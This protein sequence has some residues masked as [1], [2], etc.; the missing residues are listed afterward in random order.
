MKTGLNGFIWLLFYNS[1]KT[2]LVDNYPKAYGYGFENFLVISFFEEG[3]KKVQIL[4]NSL[5]LKK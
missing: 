1:D 5:F 2:K 4:T 3:E